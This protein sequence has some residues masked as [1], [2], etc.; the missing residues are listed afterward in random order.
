MIRSTG[1]YFHGLDRL[2]M[3]ANTVINKKRE[4]SVKSVKEI[5]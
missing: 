3:V 2:L 1:E 4:E 5:V